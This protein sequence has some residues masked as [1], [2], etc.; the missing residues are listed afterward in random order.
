MIGSFSLGQGAPNLESIAKA[1]GAAYEV[2]KTIDTVQTFSLS[3]FFIMK[4]IFIISIPE[5]LFWMTYFCSCYPMQPRPIDS[6]SK[7]G[8]K[9]DHVKG[10]IEFKNIH[11]NY[12]SRKDVKVELHIFPPVR[13]FIIDTVHSKC[14]NY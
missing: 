2:Y 4:F 14:L 5:F 6:S 10:D 9:P 7:V 11:F 8:H 13:N 1:R 12:P 3:S